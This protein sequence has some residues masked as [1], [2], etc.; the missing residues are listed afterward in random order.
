MNKN[1]LYL[2]YDGMTDPLG[3]SQVLPYIIGLSKKG[4]NYTLISFEK[5]EVFEKNK[6]EIQKICDTHQIKWIPCKYTKFPPVLSTLYDIN[7]LF[8]KVKQ[9]CKAS[10]IDIVHCRS[11]ISAFA[12]LYAKKN[13]KSKFIFDMR[14]FWVNERV[15]GNIWNLNNPIF[16]II[17]NYYKRKEIDFFSEADYTI[18]LTQNGKDEI[19]SWKNIAHQPI[20]IQVIPCCVDT[21]KFSRQQLDNS[22]LEKIAK[23]NEIDKDDFVLSYIGSIGTWYMTDEMMQFYAALLKVKKDAKFLFIT[24]SP[25]EEVY[26]HAAKYNIPT[27]NIKVVF[28]KRN[29]MPYLISLSTYSLFFIKPLYSK[30]ASSP[31]KQGE[32]MSLGVPIICNSKVGD[33]SSIINKYNAGFVIDEF[34]NSTYE[35]IISQLA[36]SHFDPDEIRKGAVEFYNLEKGVE[37]YARVYDQVLA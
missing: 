20:P 11:Y 19:H 15:D 12:G 32:I 9:V 24:G 1:V 35:K 7:V 22:T 27:A 17:Y 30:K 33:T 5:E 6:A 14:G 21:D 8:K 10:K 29:E 23:D 2:S 26:A 34:N 3:Q 16:R 25:K 13:F 31:T 4:Y 37:K 28:G 36:D 18:S